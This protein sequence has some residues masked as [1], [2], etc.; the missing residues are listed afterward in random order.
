ME[1]EE[2]HQ[3]VIAGGAAI[4]NTGGVASAATSNGNTGGIKVGPGLVGNTTGTSVL[5][6][7]EE[8]DMTPHSNNVSALSATFHQQ[9]EFIVENKQQIEQEV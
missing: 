6:E 8:D 1:S 3:V 9:V 5:N 7:E 4:A 2:S